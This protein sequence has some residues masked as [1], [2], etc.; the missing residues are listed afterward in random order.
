MK[1]SADV[2]SDLGRKAASFWVRYSRG[3]YTIVFFLVFGLGLSVWYR[4][5][6]HGDWTAEQK[7]QYALIAFRTTEFR[8]ADFD[9]AVRMTLLRA[10]YHKTEVSVDHDLFFPDTSKR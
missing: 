8:E 4:D 2:I 1:I 7:Q 10:E 6:Y 3:F 5:V 9:R